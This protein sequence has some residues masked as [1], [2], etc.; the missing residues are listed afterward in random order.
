MPAWL[1][2]AEAIPGEFAECWSSCTTTGVGVPSRRCEGVVDCSPGVASFR[3]FVEAVVK[4]K[5][6]PVEP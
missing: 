1:I 5:S 6:L 4:D 2:V 3:F